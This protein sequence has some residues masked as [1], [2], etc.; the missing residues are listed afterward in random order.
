MGIY[1]SLHYLTQDYSCIY[2][3]VPMLHREQRKH[4]LSMLCSS[5]PVL[6]LVLRIF[7]NCN[8]RKRTGNIYNEVRHSSNAYTSPFNL[9]WLNQAGYMGLEMRQA[10]GEGKSEYKTLVCFCAVY[11]QRRSLFFLRIPLLDTTCFGVTGH[12]QVYRLVWLRIL[13][14]GSLCLKTR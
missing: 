8:V 4:H 9:G 12:L 3:M 2:E 14:R 13:L 11:V 7:S 6:G 1:S 10:C 5:N